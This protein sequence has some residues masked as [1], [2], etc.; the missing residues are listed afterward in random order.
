MAGL[1]FAAWR[2]VTFQFARTAVSFTP[3]VNSRMLT[4]AFI[5]AMLYSVAWLYR[6]YSAAFGDETRR[7]I[8]V[9]VIAANLLTVGL[10][11]DDVNSFWIARPDQLTADFSRQLSISIV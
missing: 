11:T 1:G 7:A 9:L 10:V 3:I 2:L 8:L 4:G 5:V 6:R